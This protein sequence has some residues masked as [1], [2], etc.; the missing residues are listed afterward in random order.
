MDELTQLVIRAQAGDL[1]AFDV[2]VRRFQDMAVG[3]AYALLGDLHL[4]EDA[5]QEAFVGAYR[6]LGQLRAPGGC[7]RP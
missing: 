2:L 5:A 4:A 7:E 1:D 3:Y 6:N